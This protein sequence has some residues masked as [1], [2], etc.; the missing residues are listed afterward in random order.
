MSEN[1]PKNRPA[2]I[3]LDCMGGD[4]GVQ[5]VIPG[6]AL[7]AKKMP[8]IAFLLFGREDDIKPVLAKYPDLKNRSKVIHCQD[9][10]SGD[11]KPSSALRSGKQSSMRLAINSVAEGQADC[12]VSSGNTGALMAMAKLVLKCLP[13]I[14]R[15]AIASLIPTVRGSTLVLDLGANLTCTED[16]YIQFMILG[17][18]Y[19]KAVLEIEKPTA[20]LL[21]I[22]TEET[23]GHEMLQLARAI[24]AQVDI[25]GEFKG[26][27][28]G[29]D[30]GKG[31][32][33]VIVTDGFTGN[34]A[35]KTAEGISH[36]FRDTLKD[37]F[38]GS[39]FGKIAYLVASKQFGHIK[40]RLDHRVYNGGLFL[41]LNGVCIK[42]HGSAD[43]FAFSHA[44]LAGAKMV[45]NG[46]N[47][48]VA[49]EI[50]SLESQK[51]KHDFDELKHA[52]ISEMASA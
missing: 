42:S 29:D 1:T 28:E 33:D 24:L 27:V 31:S 11:D 15:P 36:L 43:D 7:A 46:F 32:V 44:V 9:V 40:K 38:G 41:G 22:G 47:N 6:A 19:A 35:L 4:L 18:V 21:N 12:V 25:P 39:L 13:G 3:A 34:V 23:K 48:V 26:F 50:K 51:Q 8:N 2:T 52:D 30:I 5:A 45:E 37:A 49:D 20:G 10:V 16:N 14:H 17:C